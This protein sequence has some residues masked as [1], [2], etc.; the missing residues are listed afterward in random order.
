MS[1]EKS[2]AEYSDNED[3][4]IGIETKY[5]LK[6]KTFTIAELNA[7]DNVSKCDQVN[8]IKIY[9]YITCCDSD[10]YNLKQIRGLIY[11][12]DKLVSR[13]FTYTS[14]VVVDDKWELNANFD[15]Q[16]VYTKAYE[17]ATIR[18]WF[19][20]GEGRPYL[21]TNRRID[22]DKSKWSNNLSFSQL[23]KNGIKHLYKT[24]EKFKEY[25]FKVNKNSGC[26]VNDYISTLDKTLQ[27][28]FFIPNN[29]RSR[30][31]CNPC[32]DDTILHIG[33]FD[34]NVLNI[35]YDIG[36]PHPDKLVFNSKDNFINYMM[37][38]DEY[39]LP[40]VL[41]FNKNGNT[42][43]FITPEYDRLFKLRGNV[44]SVNYRYLQ[45]RNDPYIVQDYKKLYY[46]NNEMFAKYEHAILMLGQ[47]IHFHYLNRYV[48]KQYVNVA[49]E[50]FRV[51]KHCHLWHCNNRKDNIVTRDTIIKF[52]GLQKPNHLNKMI[53]NWI[54]INTIPS[55]N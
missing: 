11:N 39:K 22:A 4:N 54:L 6:Q 26:V 14:E 31:V 17:G 36:V 49:S 43:K 55:N 32:P 51:M 13:G 46:N 30:I 52:I 10:T 53:K 38:I 37:S 7:M 28:T 40:G 9:N 1:L 8:D 15:I 47:V 2:W 41:M 27:Y 16:N 34:S 23:W 12:N 29:I 24:S 21:S 5:D 35:D 44:P 33:T 45:I 19:L 18:L 42:T 3:P 48:N 50:L 25:M 20:N